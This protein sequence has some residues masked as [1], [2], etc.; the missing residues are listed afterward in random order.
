MK[1]RYQRF[2]HRATVPEDRIGIASALS[3]LSTEQLQQLGLAVTS[4]ATATQKAL[5]ELWANPQLTEQAMA[6]IKELPPTNQHVITP[7]ESNYIH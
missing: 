2:C 4:P 1:Q 3:A 6:A 5:A 7:R